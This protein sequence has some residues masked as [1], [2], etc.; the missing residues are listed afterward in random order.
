[1]PVNASTTGRVRWFLTSLPQ[2]ASGATAPAILPLRSV[3]LNCFAVKSLLPRFK[4]A[5][6]ARNIKC[7]KS[8]LKGCGGT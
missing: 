5:A 4:S 3:S 8:M 2:L 1:M 7:G 6:R